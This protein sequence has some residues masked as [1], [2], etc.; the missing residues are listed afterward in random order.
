MHSHL[1]SARPGISFLDVIVACSGRQTR[2]VPV[3]SVPRH[4]R[5]PLSGC[6]RAVYILSDPAWSCTHATQRA[7]AER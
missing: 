7:S 1:Q 2:E 5:E 4:R 6:T 3:A